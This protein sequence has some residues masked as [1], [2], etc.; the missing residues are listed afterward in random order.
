NQV[1]GCV[2]G[3]ARAT[4]ASH[5]PLA[6]VIHSTSVQGAAGWVRTAPFYA[7][8]RRCDALVYVSERQRAHWARRRLGAK[9][10]VVIRNGV[11]LA[12]HGPVDASARV[13]AKLALGLA[14]AT[15]ILGSVA[16]FRPEKNHLQL[17]QALAAL[18]RA[19]VEA[20]LL[21]VGDGP[22]RAAVEALVGQLGLSQAVKFCGEQADVRPFLAAMDA[23]VLCSTSVETLPLFG[24]E[25]MAAGAPLVA[26]RVGG[27]EE[28]VEDGVD[29]LLF[30][31]CDT[32]ALVRQLKR[33]A[34]PVTR[35]RLS[36]AARRK[37]Q[38]FSAEV[39]AEQYAGLF[40]RLAGSAP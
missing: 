8:A 1:A 3:F 10:V 24:L 12:R 40:G 16:M 14:P 7:A 17:V 36:A 30:P 38:G 27:L 15:L 6:A 34:D 2:A 26:S 4:G 22:T 5:A 25:V 18:R 13:A 39:M 29:G 28:L 9:R 35:G 21:L 11:D 33:C 37:A 19:G 20:E 23:G 31:P 32:P